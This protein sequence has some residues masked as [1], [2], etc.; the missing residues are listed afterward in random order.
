[1]LRFVQ[2]RGNCTVYEW[3]MGSEPTVVERPHL[4]EPPEQVEEDAVRHVLL[5]PGFIVGSLCAAGLRRS[6]FRFPGFDLGLCAVV[7]RVTPAML[8][9]G[10]G[11][12]LLVVTEPGPPM[13]NRRASHVSSLAVLNYF[14]FSVWVSTPS[15]ASRYQA[16][17]RP[18]WGL[19]R[20]PPTCKACASI[21]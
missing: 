11:N 21:T 13:Q 12:G 3:R 15:G 20:R 6:L 19:S 7:L 9:E 2:T 14:Q 10:R 1:M 4:E 18:C 5:G 17:T 8:L 16:L